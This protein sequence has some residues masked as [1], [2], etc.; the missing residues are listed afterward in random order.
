MVQDGL[1]L[2][3]AAQARESGVFGEAYSILAKTYRVVNSA[4]LPAFV[5]CGGMVNFGRV[6][7]DLQKSRG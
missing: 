6:L 2:D 5:L 3:F 7:L 1:D 4:V